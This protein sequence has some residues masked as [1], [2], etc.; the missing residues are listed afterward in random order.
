MGT[1][2]PFVVALIAT[3][4]RPAFLKRA[5]ASVISQTRAPDA[6]I[7]VVDESRSDESLLKLKADL[8]LPS[9]VEVLTLNNRRTPGA[10]GAWNSGIDEAIRRFSMDRSTDEIYVA[11]LDDDDWWE[12]SHIE[13]C[14]VATIT[15]NNDMVAA[16]IVR[17]DDT[18][19]SGRVQQAPLRLSANDALMRNPHIQGS[20]LFVRLTTLLEAGLFDESLSSTTDRDLVI[21][22]ADLGATYVAAPLAT[23]HHDARGSRLRL[24]SVGSSKKSEGLKQFWSKYRWRMTI[25]QREAY[26]KRALEFSDADVG[27]PVAY[28]ALN[29]KPDLSYTIPGTGDDTVPLHLVVGIAADGDRLGAKRVVRLLNDLDALRQDERL[30]ALDIVV[31][32]NGDGDVH[33]REVIGTVN[34]GGLRCYLSSVD[35]QCEDAEAGCF[36]A[37]FKR[38]DGRLGISETRAMTQHYVR[39]MMRPESVAW[40]LDDDKRLIALIYEHGKLVQN[41]QDFLGSIVRLRETKTDIV[42]GVDTGAAPL[43]AAMTLRTQLVDLQANLA[44]MSAMEPDEPWPD[45]TSEFVEKTQAAPDYYHDVARLH[46]WHQELPFHFDAVGTDARVRDAFAQLCEQAPRILVGEQVF[47]PL[48]IKKNTPLTLRPSV[49]RGGNTLVFDANAL[50]D[51]PQ[52]VPTHNGRPTRRSDMVWAI[53]NRYARGRR[54]EAAPFAVLHDRSDLDTVKFHL[55]ALEDD[56]LGY[57]LYSVLI[58]I[59]ERFGQIDNLGSEAIEQARKQYRKYLSERT[60]AFVLSIHRARGAARVARRILVAPDAWWQREPAALRDAQRLLA[61]SDRVIEMLDSGLIARLK[62]DIDQASDDT[63]ESY[64]ESL[65]A[66]LEETASAPLV[67]PDW[68]EQERVRFGQMAVERLSHPGGPLAYL[69]CGQEGVVFT[70]GNDVFKYLDGWSARARESDRHFLRSI[71]GAWSDTEG[72]RPIT[73]LDERGS[74]VVLIQPYEHSAPYVGGYAVGL[75]ALLRECREYGVVCR[76]LHPRNLRVVGE[77]IRLIDYGID[78]RPLDE[79]E[80]RHMVRRAWLCWRWAQHPDLGRMMH[81]SLVADISELTGWERLEQAVLAG[82][83]K[84]DLDALVLA[85]ILATD[86]HTVLDYGCGGGRLVHDL[87]EHGVWAT[88]FDPNPSHHW[89]E[90][91]GAVFTSSFESALSVG[92]FDVV[93]CMLVLCTLDDGEYHATLINLRRAARDGGNVIVAVCNPFYTHGGDTPFQQHISV[94]VKDSDASFAWTKRVRKTGKQRRDVHR[95]LHILKRDLLRVGLFVKSMVETQTVDLE[96]LEPASDFLVLH[97]QSVAPG[98]KVSLLIRASAMAWRTLQTQIWHIVGQ[99]ETPRAF[100]ERLVV[101]DA[102]L[103][104]FTR[105]YDTANLDETRKTLAGLVADGT[106]DRIVD[107]P[108]ELAALSAIYNR[109]F[110][111]ASTYGHTTRGAPVAASLAGLE[112]CSGDYILHVDDDLLIVRKNS[113]HDVLLEM[114]SVL[115]AG[116]GAVC[117]SLNI[118]NAQDKPWTTHNSVGPW[119]VEARGTLLHRERLLASRPWPNEQ[120][121]GVLAHPWHR[122]LDR[123]ILAGGLCS[124][125]GG[126]ASTGFIH[127]PNEF[128]PDRSAWL[129]VLDRVEQGEVLGEQY[130]NVDFVGVLDDWLMPKRHE[131]LVVIACGRNVPAGRVARFRQALEMQSIQ[132]FGLVVVEDGG[133]HH[134]ADIVRHQ[135]EKMRNTTVLTLR[136]RRWAL[137]N[138]VLALHHVCVNPASIIA[139]VDLDDALLGSGALARVVY[140][141]EQGADLTIGGMR[142]TDKSCHYPLNFI[143]PR[144]NRGG[145]VW[146]HLR[147]FRRDLFDRI[148]DDALRLD[149]EYV[150]LAWDWALMIALVELANSPRSIDEPLYLHEPSGIGKRDDERRIREEIIGKIVRFYPCVPV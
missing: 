137:G 1:S 99:L 115:E 96:R 113:S 32:E 91:N 13:G 38:R 58:D 16:S 90:P 120:H 10:S 34:T 28:P 31:V 26:K 42:L 104:G 65:Y 123:R 87:C 5:V 138:I 60:A 130:G 72:L 30:A 47:R 132:D 52:A 147:A 139:L 50:V 48:Y 141:F 118:C 105:Q 98:P 93:A 73:R 24:S 140:E 127:L 14:L 92:P 46:T 70:D 84:E 17:H 107:T 23:V 45:R 85:E 4:N 9:E 94:P 63:I 126:C 35:Q 101:L 29:R 79:T 19:P 117:A 80:W 33:L 82:D 11:I 68:L 102:R 119:R 114:T 43:P 88:G 55:S 49:Q 53:L 83:A 89:D 77:H 78:L 64:L 25:K 3:H 37:G 6:L 149:G 110:D 116:E 148:P 20:N 86:P 74:E 15:G 8:D 59:A 7:I 125:R 57:A 136:E 18:N 100:H 109:W 108:V 54:V 51:V 133:S 69:G 143:N 131:S 62:N 129:A 61:M 95:P 39:A 112:A 135:F 121:G 150:H 111:T 44:E 146:Q 128:K 12:D 103:D 145:N 67:K 97:A 21:R 41:D 76:N 22:L 81:E 122:S 124:L 144:G 40:I 142:R 66:R 36:G 75:V 2:D 27:L 56:I 71:V 134:S 106:I